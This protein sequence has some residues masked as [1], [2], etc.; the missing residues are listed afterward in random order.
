MDPMIELQYKKLNARAITPE[1]ATSGAA[2]FDLYATDVNC[3]TDVPVEVSP[4]MPVVAGTGLAFEIPTG[5]MLE[6]RSR[7]GLAFKHGL[8]AFP[9]TID[10]DYR[11]EVCVLIMATTGIHSIKTGD[12]IAQACLVPCPLVVLK[13]AEELSETQRGTGGFGSTGV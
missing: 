13:P 5:Y 6:I 9:G 12:R 7:S 4:G 10:S 1:Y 11:G 2:C 8:L 3:L